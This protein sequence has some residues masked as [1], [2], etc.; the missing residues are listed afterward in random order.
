MRFYFVICY[1]FQ[2]STGQF[3]LD[4]LPKHGYIVELDAEGNLLQT[5]QSTEN[6][7]LTE[8]LEHEDG[9]YCGSFTNKFIVSLPKS[10]FRE[11]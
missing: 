2:V 8:V 11:P 6:G 3:I 9:L 10:N 1:F 7:F 4:A 5:L